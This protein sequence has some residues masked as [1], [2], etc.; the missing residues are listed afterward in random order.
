[1]AYRNLLSTAY[2]RIFF[3]SNNLF[4]DIKKKIGFLLLKSRGLAE[5]IFFWP[6]RP[7]LRLHFY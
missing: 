5:L 1:M 7:K 2:S 6:F 3:Q 4:K